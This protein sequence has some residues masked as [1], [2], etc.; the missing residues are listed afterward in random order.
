MLRLISKIRHD[1]ID[2]FNHRLGKDLYLDTNLDSGD[3]ASGHL[4]AR[5][6]ER[7][8]A[9]NEFTERTVTAS[10]PDTLSHVLNI[11]DALVIFDSRN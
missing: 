5:Q 8:L 10:R 3:T 1:A 9:G 4:E 2:L 6:G 11:Y 7:I